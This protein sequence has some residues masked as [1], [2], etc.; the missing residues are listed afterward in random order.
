MAYCIFT[1]LEETPLK[2]MCLN[3]K[4]C[5]QTAVNSFGCT[6]EHVLEK[7]RAEILKNVPEGFEIEN[8]TLK[9]MALKNPTKRCPNYWPDLELLQGAVR[10]FFDNEDKKEDPNEKQKAAE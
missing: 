7:G 2:K 9:P 6:N 3:C 4:S 10:E 5:T 1:G 8:L